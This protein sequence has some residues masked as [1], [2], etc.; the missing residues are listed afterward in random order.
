MLLSPTSSIYSRDT[1][2]SNH[3]YYP[4]SINTNHHHLARTNTSST[5]RSLS[6]ANL[7]T[8]PP[9]IT[10]PY[11]YS[12]SSA[13]TIP[14]PWTDSPITPTYDPLY[15]QTPNQI[16]D[17]DDDDDKSK[18]K[19][20][21]TDT[22]D[23]LPIPST[24]TV[25]T[26]PSL[27]SP[28]TTTTATTTTNTTRFSIA[29]SFSLTHDKDAL[30]TYRRMARKTKDAQVQMSYMLYL[31]QVAGLYQ[32]D[33]RRRLLEEA[34]YWLRRLANKQRYPPALVLKGRWYIQQEDSSDMDNKN[35]AVSLDELNIM[36]MPSSDQKKQKW[37]KA[38]QCFQSAAKAGN[39][40]AHYQLAMLLCHH[41]PSSMSKVMASLHLAADHHHLLACHKLANIYLFG[42]YNHAQNIPQAITYL[43]KAAEITHAGAPISATC[44]YMLSC[45]YAGD[46]QALGLYWQSDDI[47]PEKA[48]QYLEK[49]V[50]MGNAEAMMRRGQLYEKGKGYPQDPW[51]AFQW[52][53]QAAEIHHPPAMVAIA[54]CY[55]KGIPHHL[56]PNPTLAFKWCQRASGLDQADFLLG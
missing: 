42:E 25:I 52:Y 46:A 37:E 34:G 45:L 5:R 10:P 28:T 9:R 33:V 12:N 43:E 32:G 56:A 41:S 40:D 4:S 47:Q 35:N 50:A 44:C 11:H 54:Q 39:M 13:G 8:I 31:I 53:L 29:S 36:M 6:T 27:E 14:S 18:K 20:D 49:A 22:I 1:Y 55:A 17:D 15:T 51:Q 3:H 38:R 48:E 30:V 16:D 24:T 19:S 2:N 21:Y 23:L 7:S 26:H